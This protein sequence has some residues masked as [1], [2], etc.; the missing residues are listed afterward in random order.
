M[1]YTTVYSR[2]KSAIPKKWLK[3]EIPT[4]DDKTDIISDIFRT[5]IITFSHRL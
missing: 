3:P 2:K 1:Y 4:F 5:E